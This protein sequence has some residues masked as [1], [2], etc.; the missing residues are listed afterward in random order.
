[1]TN[2]MLGASF[3]ILLCYMSLLK[4]GES[5][6]EATDC[7]TVV[8]SHGQFEVSQTDAELEKREKIN[9]LTASWKCQYFGSLVGRKWVL[10]HCSDFGESW[11][12]EWK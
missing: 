6:L 5:F 7:P 1:M 3:R 8:G 2:V 11:K 4:F 9:R 12:M 10:Y